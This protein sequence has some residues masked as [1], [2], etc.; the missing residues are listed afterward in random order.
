MFKFFFAM[1]ERQL[2]LSFQQYIL[3]LMLFS[4]EDSLFSFEARMDQIFQSVNQA[5]LAVQ[6]MQGKYLRLCYF[7]ADYRIEKTE[8]LLN[9]ASPTLHRIAKQIEN[10]I[11]LL[12]RDVQTRGFFFNLRMELISSTKSQIECALETYD[13]SRQPLVVQQLQDLAREAQTLHREQHIGLSTVPASFA[14]ILDLEKQYH[15][16]ACQDQLERVR[17]LLEETIPHQVIQEQ[18]EQNLHCQ[19]NKLVFEQRWDE[20]M[21]NSRVNQS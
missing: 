17:N 11:V 12:L 2:E 15:D 14:S 8:P 9:Q 16:A 21:Q 7:L 3:Q 20:F 5:L 4:L 13:Q 6:D 1:M 19:F 18:L 10:D